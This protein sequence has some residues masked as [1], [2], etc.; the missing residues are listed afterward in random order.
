MI[1]GYI[2]AAVLGAL[3]MLLGLLLYRLLQT[4]PDDGA[5]EESQ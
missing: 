2:V 4:E 1:F 5:G 3:A